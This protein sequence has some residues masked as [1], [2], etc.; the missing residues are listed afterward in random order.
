MWRK[1]LELQLA[2]P[3]MTPE[4]RASLERSF[5]TEIPTW[6]PEGALPK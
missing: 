1:A 4:Y 5:R 6:W 2:A 3:D